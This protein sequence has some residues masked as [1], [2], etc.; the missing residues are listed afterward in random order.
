MR[1]EYD[2]SKAQRGK[3]YRKGA[4]LRFPIYL[5]LPLQ[6]RLQ[7]IA[8]KNHEQLREVVQRLLKKELHIN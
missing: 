7:N 4:Q 8:S 6:K 3:F 2:F 5:D 1:K